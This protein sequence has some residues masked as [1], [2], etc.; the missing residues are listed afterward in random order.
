MKTKPKYTPIPKDIGDY[1]AYSE[2]SKTGLVWRVNRGSNLVKGKEAGGIN[3]EGYYIMKLKKKRYLNHRIIYFLNTG[4]DPEEK[5][6]DHED[7]NPL[8]NKIWNL[9]LATNK[10]NQDNRKKSKANTSGVTGVYWDKIKNKYQSRIRYNYKT[11]NLG[12]FNKSDKDK[13]IAVRI[14]AELDP[15]FKDQEFRHSHND[16]HTPSP[17]MLEWAKQYLEDRIERLGWKEKWGI[18]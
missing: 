14:A 9:R 6:V 8:N 10:Q 13:A 5:Q 11:I 3:S 16:E 7:T 12:S 18:E 15:R 2:E 1:L 17:E 4:I